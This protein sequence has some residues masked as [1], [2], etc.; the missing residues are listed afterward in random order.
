MKVKGLIFFVLLLFNISSLYSEEL[1][2][3]WD[4]TI[5]HYIEGVDSLSFSEFG[6]PMPGNSMSRDL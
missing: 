4:I 5:V 3:E 6:F 2:G 1:I